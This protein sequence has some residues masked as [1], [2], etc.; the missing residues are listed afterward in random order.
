MHLPI[1]PKRDI[2]MPGSNKYFMKI[3]ARIEG[4]T[5][6]LARFHLTGPHPEV[7]V[8]LP[9]AQRPK[10]TSLFQLIIPAFDLTALYPSA[11]QAGSHPPLPLAN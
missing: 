3:K 1:N 2:T 4:P 5:G 6:T 11:R 7:K 8:K 10:E 9:V